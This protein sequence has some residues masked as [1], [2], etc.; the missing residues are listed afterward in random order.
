MT[1][2]M[3]QAEMPESGEA[4]P[5]TPV[6]EQAQVAPGTT[7]D[8]AEEPAEESAEQPEKPRGGFQR[9]I[10]ELSDERNEYRR[11]VDQLIGL[12]AHQQ[13][14]QRAEPAREP[15]PEPT[16]E[17][18][19]YDEAKYAAAMRKHLTAEATRVAQETTRAELAER[20]R[21]AQEQAR[22]ESFQEREADFAAQHPDYRELVY[23]DGLPIS[24]DVAAAIR[25]SEHGP[26]IAYHLAQNRAYA[27]ELS[28]KTARQV[29]REIGRLEERFSAPPPRPAAVPKAPPPPP[30]IEA[31]EPDVDRDPDKM[32]I[33][34]WVRWRQK[35]I[36]K[37]QGR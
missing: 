15:D 31:V 2:E 30:R 32:D 23:D 7:P 36:R 13:T 12:L 37:N 18:Y 27:A 28:R 17:Q 25:E 35:Q 20:S 3:Q 9:R 5:E 6:D 16:L 1:D 8:V 11:R 29:D 33:D 21:A 4:A 19:Q 34:E 10:K 14:E 24:A 22:L 26:R